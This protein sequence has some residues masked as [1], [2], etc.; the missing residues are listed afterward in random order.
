MHG[1]RS[2]VHDVI[3]CESDIFLSTMIDPPYI[4]RTYGLEDLDILIKFEAEVERLERNCIRSSPH[5][6]IEGLGLPNHHPEDNLFIAEKAGEVMGYVDVMPELNIGRAVLSCL[7]HPRYDGGYLSESL[8][9]HALSRSKELRLNRA[10]VNLDRENERAKG[11][12]SEKGF[13]FV[14]RFIE[15]RLD[16]PNAHLP[17]LRS[18][19]F[20]LRR[21]K[22][23][24]ERI[25]TQIQNRSFTNTWGYNPNTIEEIIY[26]TGLPHCSPGDIILAYET[27][28]PI[29]Y[30][31]TRVYHGQG[32]ARGGAEGRISM[33]GVDPD[34]RGKGVGSAVLLAG[35]SLLRK[36]GVGVVQLTVDSGNRAALAL[37]STVGFDIWKCSLWYEKLL[38]EPLSRVTASCP[39][40]RKAPPGT[41]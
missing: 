2:R 21:L 35:L 15:L 11:F 40:N 22:R 8:I 26:R 1:L 13:R 30:C 24:E 4:I 6:L 31:W 34:H 16:L 19:A 39:G 36:R 17:N 5:R 25:L 20:R 38:N 32:N 27:N 37:Y 29:G 28:R 12:F 33:L 23:G 14:R 41:R 18:N 3:H 7:I 10:H 9:E